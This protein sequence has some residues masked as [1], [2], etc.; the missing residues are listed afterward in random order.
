[1]KNALRLL[2][3][4]TLAAAGTAQAAS[5]TNTLSVTATVTANCT[6]TTTPVAFGTYD[7]ASSSN[8]SA[9]GAVS[10]ACAKGATGLSVG[11]ANGSNYANLQRNMKGAVSTDLLAYKL[12]Q[13]ASNAQPAAACPAY[14]SGTEWTDVASLGLT[15]SPGKAART[16]NVCGQLAPAQDVSVDNYSDTVVATINF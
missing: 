8:V 4:T 2:A 14:G 9:A 3:L 13:P 12:V 7:P 1:M 10:V 15:T 5:A 6:I 16:Y 11:L